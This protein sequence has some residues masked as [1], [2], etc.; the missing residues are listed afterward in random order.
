MH[1]TICN[2]SSYLETCNGFATISFIVKRKFEYYFAENVFDE[3]CTKD[4]ICD[5][6]FEI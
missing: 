6:G 1:S 5:K 3:I 4:K 2:D